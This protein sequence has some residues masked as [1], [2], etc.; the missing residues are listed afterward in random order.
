MGS[1]RY[2]WMTLSRHFFLSGRENHVQMRK[3][4]I[5]FGTDEDGD[6]VISSPLPCGHAMCWKLLFFVLAD[7]VHTGSLLSALP[8]GPAMC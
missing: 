5:I 1:V 6:T 3:S 8:C 2:V 4:D 7:L